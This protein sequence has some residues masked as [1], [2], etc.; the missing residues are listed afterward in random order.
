[1]T[2]DQAVQLMYEVLPKSYGTGAEAI[3]WQT[4]ITELLAFLSGCIPIPPTPASM[5]TDVDR[6]IVQVMLFR[7]FHAV[8]IYGFK[9]QKVMAA[10]QASVK[11]ASDEQLT[12]II[13]AASELRTAA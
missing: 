13:A 1:M 8:G 3:P 2:A 11:P 10:V 6:P 5:R 4:I 12:G 9:A 7:R